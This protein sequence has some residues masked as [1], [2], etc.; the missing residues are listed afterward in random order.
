MNLV[1]PR[2]LAMSD[3]VGVERDPELKYWFE[4]RSK[5]KPGITGSWQVS[6]RSD[7][8]L[9]EMVQ[10]DLAYI[11]DWSLWLD[12]AILLRTVPAVLGGRGAR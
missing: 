3:L 8:G 7:L 2:P 5:V 9:Q 11:Q 6:G 10:L 4:M 12:L 1:G